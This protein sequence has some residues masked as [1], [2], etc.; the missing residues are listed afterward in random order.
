MRLGRTLPF[1][2][3][4]WRSHPTP[5]PPPSPPFPLGVNTD[6]PA[7][8]SH[9]PPGP[10]QIPFKNAALFFVVGRGTG[11]P[12]SPFLDRSHAP[13]FCQKTSRR[14]RNLLDGPSYA[15]LTLR[16]LS[17]RRTPR[18][19]RQNEL[20]RH[21]PPAVSSDRPALHAQQGFASQKINPKTLLV[22]EGRRAH[23]PSQHRGA[24]AIGVNSTATRTS[25]QGP[26]SALRFNYY[27]QQPIMQPIR[28]H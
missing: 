4:Y 27:H 6:A 13:V 14:L 9:M 22:K 8:I 23:A 10:P 3:F 28:L 16:P 19:H 20:Q 21:A 18:P 5:H 2:G 1:N 7:Q 17:S 15:S 11:F 25:S 24:L 12:P 26:A